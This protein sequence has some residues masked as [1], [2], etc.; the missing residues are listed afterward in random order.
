[1]IGGISRKK[2]R[3]FASTL[4][5]HRT[6]IAR[7]RSLVPPITSVHTPRRWISSTGALLGQY[8]NREYPTVSRGEI[9]SFLENNNL[10]FRESDGQVV[11]YECPFCHP[12]KNDSDRNKLHVSTTKNGVFFCH[13][14]G[15]KGG[16]SRF[17]S[18]LKGGDGESAVRWER[19]TWEGRWGSPVGVCRCVCEV[20]GGAA[21]QRPR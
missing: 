2:V 11:V 18:L 8:S 14:C 3:A 17:R 10:R 4:S 19:E 21:A 1:M 7:L 12:I 15:S 16:W 5:R 6:R 9:L 13:R 20:G